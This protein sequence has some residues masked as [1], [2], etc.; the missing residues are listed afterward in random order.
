MPTFPESPDLSR[1]NAVNQILASIAME[2]LGLSHIINAE[3]E[4]L[5]FALGTLDGITG[6]NAEIEDILN[7][8]DSAQKLMSSVS[9]NQMFLRSKMM[10][11]LA[12]SNMR[13]ATGATGA[14]GPQGPPGTPGPAG[15]TGPDGDTGPDGPMGPAGVAGAMGPAGAA[16]KTGPTGPAGNAGPAGDEGPAGPDGNTGATGSTISSTVGCAVAGSAI[17]NLIANQAKTISLPNHIVAN[18]IGFDS[19]KFIISQSGTYRVSYSI[20]LNDACVFQSQILKNSSIPVLGTAMMPK[21]ATKSF[22]GETI[23]VLSRSDTIELSLFST[24]S[25]DP[26]LVPGN[27]ATLMLERLQ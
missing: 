22:S 6:P 12:S 24:T 5:Q 26:V 1:D 13:G 14:I 2:E 9:Q 11:A 4:K 8:N 25:I 20:N 10:N 7:A 15:A 19:T 16:G 27:G 23:T 18:K 3:G 17:I 21:A